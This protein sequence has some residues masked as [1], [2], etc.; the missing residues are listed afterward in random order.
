[1]ET[2]I[3]VKCGI[4]KNI[5]DFYY[6]KQRNKYQN[7]CKECAKKQALEYQKNNF[8][9]IK[10]QKKEYFKKYRQNNIERLK[11]KDEKFRN[12]HKDYMKKYSKEYRKTH[13]EKF[14]EYNKKNNEKMKK[15]K[16]KVKKIKTKEQIQL[17]KFKQQIRC[18]ISK[19]FSRKK[20]IKNQSTKEILGCSFESFYNHLLST[21]KYNYGHEWNGIEKVHIDHIIPLA[22]AKME[23]EVIKLSR[24]N[25]LQLL[26]AKDN[27]RKNSKLDWKLN[28]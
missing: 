27:L 25:N 28:N 5:N 3:C 20:F 14:K 23:E 16:T 1:M 9:K 15:E 12:L 8:E 24:Y 13:K 22:T 21:Y 17:R 7:K 18:L 11:E 19:S 6:L 26:K 2:K 4:E 10:K